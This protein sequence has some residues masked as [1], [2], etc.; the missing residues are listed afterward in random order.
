LFTILAAGAA[1]LAAG[2]T[3][4][5]VRAVAP[6]GSGDTTG[7][8]PTGSS[9]QQDGEQ[10]TAAFLRA[11]QAGDLS[12]AA[13]Y[14]DRPGAAGAALAAYRKNLHL[15]KLTGTTGS[16][17]VLTDSTSSPRVS[18]SF[19]VSATVA[20][21]DSAG[22]LS[23]TWSYHSSVVAYQQP[24]SHAWYIA[25][26]PDDLAPNLTASTH[27][28]AVAAAPQV[29]SVT[30]SS[31]NGLTSYG[32]AGLGT[33]A[34]IL[35]RKPPA[36]EGRPGIDVEIQDARD[37]L[38]PGSQAAVVSPG[39]VPSLATTISARAEKDA[40]GAVTQYPQSSIVAVQPSTGRILAIANND[41]Y[42]DFA[43][44]ADVA[45]GSTG[46]ILA[47]TTLLAEGAVTASTPVGCPPVYTVQ[48]IQYH[49]DEGESEPVSTPL[50]YDF[51]QSCNNAFSRWWSD[52]SN[53]RLAATD[54]KYYG[55]DEPWD[56]G[57][58]ESASYYDQPASASGSELAENMF[59]EGAIT[60]SPLAMASVAATV[61]HGSFRQP[62]ILP[63]AT[64][65]T[66]TP[67]PASVDS[68]LKEMMRDVVTEGTAAGLGFGPD[69][70]AKTGTADIDG[71]EQPN[72]WTV[73]FD[74]GQD[75]AVACL[76]LDAGYGA[77]YAAPE[78]SHFLNQLASA[79]S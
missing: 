21:S 60:A 23:G 30:D 14:T 5:I 10:I 41:G 38:V 64:Q 49:N 9:P 3:V 25:W 8:A 48:G 50:S 45:P 19:E 77:Q 73:A 76:V 37:R 62:V 71:Q 24:G 34:G 11:W 69:V 40:R 15:R 44:D 33:I 18:A 12:Q 46:K 17:T 78:A 51:A 55:L 47:S 29:V 6:G 75:I 22:A 4:I 56:I 59:G 36:G 7:F 52:A 42:N 31:G 79:G 13:R 65:V 27:L 53:G 54:K 61:A 16:V 20:A 74:P 1:V 2:A 43:L 32:D 28:A 57:I 72:S 67:L 70:Y 39:N 58:G 35:E 66:A 68:Q 63:G 26:A